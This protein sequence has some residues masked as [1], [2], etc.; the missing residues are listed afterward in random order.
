VVDVVGAIAIGRRRRGRAR[1]IIGGGFHLTDGSF[2][3]VVGGTHVVAAAII[4]RKW[5]SKL[6][7]CVVK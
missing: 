7:V 4:V 3:E 2:R 6:H 1:D 5:G